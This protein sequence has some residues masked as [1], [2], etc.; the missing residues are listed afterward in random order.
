MLAKKL[1]K[2]NIE[3]LS[4]ISVI[5][6]I[7]FSAIFAEEISGYSPFKIDFTGASPPGDRHVLGTD[8]LG[9]DILSRTLIGGRI[10]I[11]IGIISR[12]GSTLMGL[13]IGLVVGLSTRLI[14]SLLNGIL[15]VFLA[16]PSLL[17]AMG[18]AVALGEGYRTIII[19]IV[20]GTW[21]PVARF[22]SVKV[23]EINSEDFIIS[24]KA[25]SLNIQFRGF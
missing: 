16:V 23:I 14:R 3:I 19:A 13:I 15:D 24:A 4:Y 17:L 18:L 9:R 7:A 25:S 22:V 21:A 2:N 20:I 8:F 11:I 5:F 12:M 6:L 10:S 1:R